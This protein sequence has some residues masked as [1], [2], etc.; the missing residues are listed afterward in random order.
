MD[1]ASVD[2]HD[3]GIDNYAIVD[4]IHDWLSLLVDTTLTTIQTSTGVYLKDNLDKAIT[5][6]VK[7]VSRLNQNERGS[8]TC[9]APNA[10]RRM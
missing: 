10:V 4:S 8:P 7:V 6:L 9:T 2:R 3:T 5:S 1:V